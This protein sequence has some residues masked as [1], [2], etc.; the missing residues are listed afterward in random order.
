MAEKGQDS[1]WFPLCVA[2][3][4]A[5]GAGLSFWFSAAAPDSPAV[6]G[7]PNGFEAWLQGGPPPAGNGPLYFYLLRGARWCG[8]DGWHPAVV[9]CLSVGLFVLFF[10]LFA[11]HVFGTWVALGSA[12]AI[13]LH[14]FL[15]ENAARRGGFAPYLFF[16]F[17]GF[18]ATAGLL[19]RKENPP[20][21]RWAAAGVLLTPAIFIRVEAAAFAAVLLAA[22]ARRGGKWAFRGMFLGLF[23]AGT[24]FF[25]GTYAE[26]IGFFGAAGGFVLAPAGE[27]DFPAFLR[28]LSGVFGAAPLFAAV[29][30]AI[31]AAGRRQTAPWAL[32]FLGY[33][34]FLVAWYLAGRYEYDADRYFL[35]LPSLLLPFF[36]WTAVRLL[37][38][39]QP[40]TV[41]ITT[42]LL[43][44]ACAV[45]Y[46]VFTWRFLMWETLLAVG[47]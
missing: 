12:G 8:L 17:L 2:V 9:D 18:W 29:A 24:L 32:I 10:A 14:P 47:G 30:G 34:G 43:Y 21:W 28:R 42:L 37:Q 15:L 36:G 5:L 38:G 23:A 33:T 1:K 11:R 6:A 45:Y 19:E 27:A 13:L 39:R 3:L 40:L 31:R 7:D 16:L 22:A 25:I 4:A 26:P 20:F 44:G 35:L 41:A 46:A